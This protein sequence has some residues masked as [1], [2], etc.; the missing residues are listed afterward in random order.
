MQDWEINIKPDGISIKENKQRILQDP[1]TGESVSVPQGAHRK[2]VGVGDF[3]DVEAYK[4]H[5]AKLLGGTCSHMV[6]ETIT[7]RDIS[8]TNLK[9]STLACEKHV[10]T[11]ETLR[12]KQDNLQE[13]HDRVLAERDEVL[14]LNREHIRDILARE[15]EKGATAGVLKIVTD[16]LDEAIALVDSLS[17]AQRESEASIQVLTTD[18]LDLKRRVA[19]LVVKLALDGKKEEEAKEKEE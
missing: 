13:S 14:Q 11:I 4:A 18:N 1:E 9:A 7:N 17:T 12:K 6:A 16:N 15:E 19:G 8:E 5:V 10:E 2:A 3:Q